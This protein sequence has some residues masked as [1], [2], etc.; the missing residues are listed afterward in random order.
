MER[1][2]NLLRS[3]LM[4]LV[5][6]LIA[7]K[8]KDN[9]PEVR[10]A[11]SD[12]VE[13]EPPRFTR[14]SL[15]EM[16][17]LGKFDPDKQ[18]NFVK[19]PLKYADREGMYIHKETLSAFDKMYAAALDQGI[20]LQIRSATRNFDYQKGI[21]ERKWT[22][23]TKLST[24][25]DASVSFPKA[26]DRASS[27]LQYSS[28]PGTSRHHWGTDIDLNS[29]DNK[30]FESGEGLKLFQWLEANAHLYGFCRPY[31]AKNA[32]RPQGYNEEKWHWSYMPLSE[33]LTDYAEAWLTEKMIKGFMG[34]EVAE[35]LKVVRNYVLGINRGCRH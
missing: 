5:V 32:E 30:W 19:I 21:W 10:L 6:T 20:N 31:T 3:L 4:L 28:M 15:K 18:A 29:F 8:G 9:T 11:V 27:I 12:D 1:K 13:V 23:E 16:Y 34:S 7:C 14:D 25:Q 22:G 2:Q 24:G 17:L 35:E 26:I 33:E